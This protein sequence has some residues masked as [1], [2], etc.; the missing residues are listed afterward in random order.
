[1]KNR[2]K[3]LILLLTM[4]F[5]SNCVL[6]TTDYYEDYRLVITLD[7]NKLYDAPHCFVVF[8]NS[9][10]ETKKI[11]F[12]REKIIFKEPYYYSFD[13]YGN[14]EK[15]GNLEGYF[16]QNKTKKIPIPPIDID[17][18]NKNKKIN[19]WKK[20]KFNK[21]NFIYYVN[22]SLP[23]VWDETNSLEVVVKFIGIEENGKKKEY[24]FRN[25][26]KKDIRYYKYYG[27]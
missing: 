9:L 13:I 24:N 25:E 4:L 11:G 3:F 8:K 17:K 18:V 12:L 19:Q 23:I 6:F 14:F 2:F 27:V 5:L 16:I 10:F 21:Y 1:M 7:D 26:Y 20:D 22:E 15:I